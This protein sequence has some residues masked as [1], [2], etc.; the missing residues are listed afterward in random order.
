MNENI[1]YYEWTE[2][3]NQRR[4]N[5]LKLSEIRLHLAT[6]ISGEP[7]FYSAVP[8]LM[9]DGKHPYIILSAG[10][11]YMSTERSRYGKL[12]V[13]KRTDKEKESS[14]VVDNIYSGPV[15]GHPWAKQ[16]H[17]ELV[18]MDCP[19]NAF[20]SPMWCRKAGS[21]KDLTPRDNMAV[22]SELGID[23]RAEISSRDLKKTWDNMAENAACIGYLP[24]GFLW[25]AGMIKRGGV[26]CVPRQYDIDLN[27]SG[28][29]LKSDLRHII[30]AQRWRA[31]KV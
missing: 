18:S 19:I 28:A 14:V 2:I 22:R 9:G 13:G 1:V 21:R 24:D 23:T 10:T 30:T 8:V 12:I 7:Y 20:N 29:C 11:V 4:T 27:I 17:A 31:I 26:V 5:I 15:N 3:P 16:R 6:W 25:E